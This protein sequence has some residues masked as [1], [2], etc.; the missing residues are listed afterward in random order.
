[1]LASDST[2]DSLLDDFSFLAPEAA[3]EAACRF[4]GM[5]RRRPIDVCWI[6]LNDGVTWIEIDQVLKH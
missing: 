1:M 6:E 3:A 4:G 2:R 5:I